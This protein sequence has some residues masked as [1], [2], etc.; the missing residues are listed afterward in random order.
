M[1]SLERCHVLAIVLAV[2]GL[3]TAAHAS[4]P[5]PYAVVGCIANGAFTTS[6]LTGDGFV[7]PAIRALEGKTVR[8][9]GY[10]SPGDRFQATAVFVVDQHCREDLFRRDFLCDPCATLPG[11]PHKMLPPQPGKKA[12]LS[13]E[14]IREFDNLGR[15][16]RR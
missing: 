4:L 6:G 11:R 2:A 12:R 8:V 7:D 3:P 10:L 1:A 13:P 15:R 5:V 9:E 14:A 16:M